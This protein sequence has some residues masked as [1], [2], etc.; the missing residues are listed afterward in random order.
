MALNTLHS[1]E[2]IRESRSGV[3]SVTEKTVQCRV[4]GHG[5]E[6]TRQV[7]KTLVR[8]LPATI[9]ESLV[10]LMIKT[11]HGLLTLIWEMT[12]VGFEPTPFRTV[13]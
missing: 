4:V 13:T 9:P 6:T 10:P 8:T 1:D 12:R 5:V 3:I 11:L 2:E 7:P